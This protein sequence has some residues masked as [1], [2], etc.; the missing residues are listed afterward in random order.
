MAEDEFAGISV[1]ERSLYLQVPWPDAAGL[2]QQQRGRLT[3]RLAE[4]SAEGWRQPTRCHLWDVG[5]LIAHMTDTNRWTLAALAA[6]QDPSLPSPFEGFDNRVTPHQRVVAARGRSSTDL[7]K[8]LRSGTE[9]VAKALAAA[10]D[11]EFPLVRYGRVRYR[12]P[13]AGLHLFWDSWLHERDVLLPLGLG[14]D[15]TDEELEATAAYAMLFAGALMGPFDPPVT[16]DVL[17]RDRA[18]RSLRLA[19]GATVHLGLRP[20]SDGAPDYHIVGSTLP[21]I[22]ALFG[23]GSLSEVVAADDGIRG[24]LEAVPSCMRPETGAAETLGVAARGVLG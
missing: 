15:H 21:M 1:T 7:L 6:A 11:P 3:E 9:E 5:D 14:G 8:D 19:L 16:I 13:V 2:L 17:L 12:A 20:E 22:D 4:L 23:R 24:R 18:D 10:S